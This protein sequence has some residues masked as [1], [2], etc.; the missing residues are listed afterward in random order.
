MHMVGKSTKPSSMSPAQHWPP[1]GV[2]GRSLNPRAPAHGWRAAQVPQHPLQLQPLSFQVLQIKGLGSIALCPSCQRAS[3][4]CTGSG[5][6][7][8]LTRQWV[9][10]LPISKSTF[11]SSGLIPSH[12][13]SFQLWFSRLI[14]H[15]NV[16]STFPH[17][18]KMQIPQSLMQQL[19]YKSVHMRLQPAAS[20]QTQLIRDPPR[21]T[22]PSCQSTLQKEPLTLLMFSRS[23]QHTVTWFRFMNTLTVSAWFGKPGTAFL[24]ML[25][26]ETET[27]PEL[28]NTVSVSINDSFSLAHTHAFIP[29]PLSSSLI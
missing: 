22:V 15:S 27:N 17:V 12:I 25:E 6:H 10:V 28:H 2:W 3:Y 7:L 20:H 21:R 16:L 8:M 1:P 4:T 26:L 9:I 23:A 14:M 5:I 24:C 19:H 29:A 18:Q 11:L 13:P